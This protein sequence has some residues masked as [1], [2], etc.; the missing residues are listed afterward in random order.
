MKVYRICEKKQDKL[1]TLFHGINRSREM[2]VGEWMT[3]N[4][5]DVRDGSRERAKLY[6]S[7]FH[8]LESLD[9]CRAFSKRFTA[10]RKLCIVE[11]EIG[12]NRWDKEHSPSNIILAEKIKLIKVV[13]DI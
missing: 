10:D 12:E 7:G 9:E 11:C 8:V 3:A 2:K 1:L 6:K 13:E 5:K 4:I